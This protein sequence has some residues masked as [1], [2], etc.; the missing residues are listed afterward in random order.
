MDS[1]PL[2]APPIGLH[3]FTLSGDLPNL[4]TDGNGVFA[5][6]IEEEVY[7][8]EKDDIELQELLGPD[9]YAADVAEIIAN[10]TIDILHPLDYTKKL[11]IV[12][13]DSVLCDPEAAGVPFSKIRPH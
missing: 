3:L 13:V 4:P 12:D 2:S 9:M 8:S 5:L 7:A 11:V 1:I 6:S 10:H